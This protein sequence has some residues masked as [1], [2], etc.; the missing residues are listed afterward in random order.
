MMTSVSSKSMANNTGSRILHI[1]ISKLPSKSNRAYCF[2]WLYSIAWYTRSWDPQWCRMWHRSKAWYTG[3]FRITTMSSFWS[4]IMGNNTASRILHRCTS[5]FPSESN[6]MIVRGRLC[7]GRTSNYPVRVIYEWNCQKV[8]TCATFKKPCCCIL[9]HWVCSQLAFICC[10]GITADCSFETI[11]I[12]CF[13]I[14]C[15]LVLF[16]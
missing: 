11:G 12:V 1:F 4:K 10:K 9:L 15:F 13:A 2:T 7:V 6:M 8:G 5:K 3:S 16:I 14:Q